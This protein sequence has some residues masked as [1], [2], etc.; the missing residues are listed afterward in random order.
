[1]A[2]AHTVT[3]DF[4]SARAFPQ[5]SAVEVDEIDLCLVNCLQVAPR[6]SWARIGQVLGIDPVTAA[7]R[8]QRMADAGVAW[9]TGRAAGHTAPDSC[10]A[11]IELSCS[12]AETMA[13]AHRIAQLPHV[14]SVEH[15]SG[16]RALTLMAEIRDLST[17]SGFLLE[18]LGRIPGVI[19]TRSHTITQIL[20]MGD[21][22]RLKVLDRSQTAAL[23]R[24][25]R[26]QTARPGPVV[27]R[28]PYDPVDRQL[29][30]LLGEDGRMPVSTMAA[31]LELAESTVRRRLQALI[32]ANRVVLRCD[33]ALGLSGWPVITWVWGYLRPDDTETIP[34]IMQHISG[35]RVCWRISGGLPNVLL[36]LNTHT[37]QEQP[38]IEA[39]LAEVAPRLSVVD[40]AMVLRSIKRSGRELDEAGRSIRVIP[41]DIWS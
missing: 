23:A 4:S 3:Q 25:S 40:R 20:T 41:M 39:Q 38:V 33:M 8:W 22:W 5:D 28:R 10:L 9:V 11:V 30:M 14:L 37:V 1:M 27:V 34:A 17:L 16:P 24:S 6:A 15:T 2:T 26:I 31:R 13:I 32:E 12:A 19:S 18:S 35:I 29:I 7:R 21:Q 36:A